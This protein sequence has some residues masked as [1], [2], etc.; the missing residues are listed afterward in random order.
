M[1]SARA[2]IVPLPFV[3]LA[4]ACSKDDGIDY[5]GPSCPAGQVA[6]GRRCVDVATDPTSC[7]GCGIPCSAGQACQGG[8]CVCLSGTLCNGA[9]VDAC[10]EPSPPA[11]VTSAPGAY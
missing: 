11:L 2:W 1:T 10:A 3:L 6:C 4:A 5:V 9:C 7:G 8:A